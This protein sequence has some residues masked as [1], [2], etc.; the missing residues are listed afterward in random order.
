MN[1]NSN[2]VIGIF[3]V[4]FILLLTSP[5]YCSANPEK[6]SLSGLKIAPPTQTDLAVTLD[7][8]FSHQ[9]DSS[10]ENQSSFLE[11]NQVQIFE[12]GKSRE[13]NGELKRTDRVIKG[14]SIVMALDHSVSMAGIN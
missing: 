1:K 14:K 4:T 12:E 6:Y 11:K 7:F 13:I 9:K 2:I 5:A 10:K 8:T 3:A